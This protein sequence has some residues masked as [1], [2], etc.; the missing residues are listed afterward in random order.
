MEGREGKGGREGKAGRK[1]RERA[2]GRH[3]ARRSPDSVWNIE[4]H[5]LREQIA[6]MA[7][8]LHQ[9]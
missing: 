3:D 9:A 5:H 8:D 7:K 4:R 2:E 6:A 1:G